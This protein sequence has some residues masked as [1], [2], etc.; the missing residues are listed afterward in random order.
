MYRHAAAAAF[1]GRRLQP[2]DRGTVKFLHD[3]WFP[4]RYPDHF[5][6]L[7]TSPDSALQSEVLLHP[8]TNEFAALAVWRQ[9]S[10]AQVDVEDRDILPPAQHDG[11]RHDAIYIL[12]IGVAAEYRRCGLASRLIR[13]LIA[14]AEADRNP[15]C[16]CVYLHVLATNEG[17]IRFYTSHGF[18][19]HALLK[20]YYDIAG[21]KRDAYTYVYFLPPRSGQPADWTDCVIQSYRDV[22]WNN[23]CAVM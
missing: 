20:N 21:E 7:A 13:N 8:E 19:R 14:H 9:C 10:M 2:K 1:T 3:Q 11:S 4:V 15:H 16:R 18:T 17:A 5:F 23:A 22:C 6:T 12:T